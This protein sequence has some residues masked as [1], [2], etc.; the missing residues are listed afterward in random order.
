[1]VP[2]LSMNRATDDSRPTEGTARAEG[3]GLEEGGS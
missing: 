1:M 3:Q 2:L